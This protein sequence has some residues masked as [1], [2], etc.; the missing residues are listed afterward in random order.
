MKTKEVNPKRDKIICKPRHQNFLP[1]VQ[2]YIIM[3]M[4]SR[5]KIFLWK[6]AQAHGSE[7]E[8]AALLTLI[9]QIEFFKLHFDH[10]Y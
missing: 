9:K 2:K 8:E 7:R 4:T 5:R 1:V 10:C 3:Q 6:V